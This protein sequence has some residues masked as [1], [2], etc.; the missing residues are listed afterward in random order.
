MAPMAVNFLFPYS[1]LQLGSLVINENLYDE[2]GL[3]CVTETIWKQST[4][5]EEDRP[6]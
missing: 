4:S 5:L 6:N 2:G 3:C 1:K